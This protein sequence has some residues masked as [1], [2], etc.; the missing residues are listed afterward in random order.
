MWT[1]REKC[2]SIAFRSPWEHPATAAPPILDL[3]P[4]F[5]KSGFP[6]AGFLAMGVDDMPRYRPTAESLRLP[7]PLT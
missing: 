5:F 6:V 7:E 4:S 2:P 1:L 3:E